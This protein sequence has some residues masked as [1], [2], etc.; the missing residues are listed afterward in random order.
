MISFSIEVKIP[1]MDRRSIEI[2]CPHCGLHTWTT[3]GH[4]KR[5]EFIVC[6]GC[7]WNIH[8]EDKD[9]SMLR[10]IRRIRR[11]LKNLERII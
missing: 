6:R 10:A 7:H 5:R 4:V 2:P 3:I 11:S 9:A 8:L 1:N